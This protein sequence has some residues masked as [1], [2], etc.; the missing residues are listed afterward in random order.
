[1]PIRR[2]LPAL[3]ALALVVAGCGQRS[4]PVDPLAQ[5]YPVSV[6]GAGDRALVLRAAPKRI[7]A[8][9]PGPAA[10]LEELGVGRRLVGVPSTSRPA[11]GRPVVRP[12][13]QMDV[14]AVIAARPD[15][16]VATPSVDPV[17]LARAERESGAVAY[18]QPAL[19]LRD[20]QRGAVELGFLVGEPVRAR[21]LSGRIGSAAARVETRLGDT[22]RVR[23]FVD[24]GFFVTIRD[25]SL[26]G[27]LVRRAR[28]INVAGATP[29]VEPL[30]ACRV[31]ALD[32]DVYLATTD[33]RV[34]GREFR[35]RAEACGGEGARGVRFAVVP[36]TLVTE[37]GPQIAQGLEAVAR[38][39][40]PDALG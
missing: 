36:A 30:D 33:S 5:S 23:V 9:D 16:I 37:P 20:V 24:T 3:A 14:R 22:P 18:V 12:N 13:G 2:P 11:R 10:L 39:L 15:L 7:V 31:L 29:P 40:H 19:S 21:R 32:P 4:E 27:D 38:A 8:V 35:R 1:M 26:L 6:R 17:D 34:T 25:R 28:G